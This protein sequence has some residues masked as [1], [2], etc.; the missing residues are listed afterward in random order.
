[1]TLQALFKEGEEELKKQEVGEADTDA[2]ILLTEC[3]KITRLDYLMDPKKKI[4]SKDVER[5]REWIHL[6]AEGMPVQ[7]ITGEQ[8]F[9]GLPFLVNEDVLIPRQDTEILVEAVLAQLKDHATVLDLG[10]GSGCI[11]LSIMALKACAY[12]DGT[13]ISEAALKV[14]VQNEQGIRSLNRKTLPQ[15][16]RPRIRWLQGD[17]FEPV[18]GR[19]DVIVSNPPYIS[20]K[21]ISHLMR[22]VRCHEP[23]I[24]L[25]GSEDGLAFYRRIA[26]EAPS[27]LSADGQLFLEIGCS[28]AEDV[29]S[30]LEAAGFCRIQ[31]K[32]DLA[33]LD[34]VVSA[35]LG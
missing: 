34:R 24:A 15:G 7:Y 3:L 23:R 27:H 18:T 10:T 8:D 6:R 2:W 19:Y 16:N 13:D 5:Y 14:A 31:I 21:E 30:I 29:A 17:L 35:C 33:G 28:Q 25:D 20:S 26:K 9:M 22:E 11:L 1:M 32:Q 4:A 12:G